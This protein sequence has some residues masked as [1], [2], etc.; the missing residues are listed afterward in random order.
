VIKL[1]IGKA[2]AYINGKPVMLDVPGRII[3]GRTMVPLRFVGEGL[4]A[5]IKWDGFT[6]AI[7][8]VSAI[9]TVTRVI[10]GDTIEVNVQGKTERIRL[11]GVD[12]PE[13]TQQVEPFGKEANAFTH[14]ILQGKEVRLEFDVQERDRFGRLL[15][16]V[17]FGNTMFNEMLLREGFA[18]VATFPPNVKY[19]ERFT[20]A[21]Q[22]ARDARRGL[23]RQA[24]V[25]TPSSV[26]SRVNI[27][28]AS[29]EELK[30]IIHIDEIRAA[31]IIRLRPFRSADEIDR[32]TG[33]GEVRLRE[34]KEQG[35]AYV[36]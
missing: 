33:I 6:I 19:V 13:S 29:V 2:V 14:R 3:E 24:T 7:T 25:S 11:I 35:I 28:T 12:T 26:Q 5:G 15:A 9:N 8:G 36:P 32:V 22:E 4:G 16:Y 20:R 30:R 18:Q 34:I 31:E 17:W 1:T 21:Q 23:W 10:D 27:N